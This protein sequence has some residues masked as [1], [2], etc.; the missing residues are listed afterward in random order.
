MSMTR[1]TI[2]QGLRCFQIPLCCRVE[3]LAVHLYTHSSSL[4]AFYAIGWYDLYPI[5]TQKV[6]AYRAMA[7]KTRGELQRLLLNIQPLLQ[8]AA[9]R[10]EYRKELLPESTRAKNHRKQVR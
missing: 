4:M 8:T 5:L 9:R 10:A 6:V 1:P 7:L 2:V 3:S